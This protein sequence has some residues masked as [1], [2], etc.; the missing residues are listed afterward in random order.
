MT[1]RDPQHRPLTVENPKMPNTY[2]LV[3]TRATLVNSRPSPSVGN[4]IR[5]QSLVSSR[6]LSSNAY[7]SAPAPAAPLPSRKSPRILQILLQTIRQ[8]LVNSRHLSSNT[9]TSAPAPT[10][11]LPSRKSSKILQILLQTIRQSLVNSCHLSYNAHTSTRLLAA[12]LPSRKSLKSCKSCF[13]QSA[14]HSYEHSSV[15]GPSALVATP[16]GLRQGRLPSATPCLDPSTSAT[17][18]SRAK[19]NRAVAELQDTTENAKMCHKPYCD[20][21]QRRMEQ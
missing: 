3:N 8:S 12:P 21:R 9:H 4:A 17:Y 14:Q 13:R 16:I 1:T 6:H 19:Q 11:P 5:S 2:S 7:T 10:S 18:Q 20:A 15:P